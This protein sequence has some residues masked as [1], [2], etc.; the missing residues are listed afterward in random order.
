MFGGF[1]IYFLTALNR[2]F[3]CAVCV[4]RLRTQILWR[5]YAKELSGLFSAYSQQLHAILTA[6]IEGWSILW[7]LQARL[8]ALVCP[9][10]LKNTTPRRINAQPRAQ[11][12][13]DPLLSRSRS[14]PPQPASW[15]LSCDFTVE[16]TLSAF[17][18]HHC[19]G[20]VTRCSRGMAQRSQRSKCF[21]A[22]TVSKHST[23][24]CVYTTYIATEEIKVLVL[25][26]IILVLPLSDS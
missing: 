3:C 2:F 17:T 15:A 1:F 25:I 7:W 26:I 10:C 9:G 5:A 13:H 14:R 19:S 18:L 11:S 4:N 23:Y 8:N 20:R 16:Q 21:L 24:A 22:Y 12:H 6:A